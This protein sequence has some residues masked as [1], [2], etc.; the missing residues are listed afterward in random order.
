MEDSIIRLDQDV[1]MK[2]EWTGVTDKLH[3]EYV[4][5]DMKEAAI[6]LNRIIHY[7]GEEFG[8]E[9]YVYHENLAPGGQF[10]QELSNLRSQISHMYRT[11]DDAEL[12]KVMNLPE[13]I[14][15]LQNF[16]YTAATQF[17]EEEK[18]LIQ[19][20]LLWDRESATIIPD[21]AW[22][23]FWKTVDDNKM[24]MLDEVNRYGQNERFFY[25]LFL[26]RVR[27]TLSSNTFTFEPMSPFKWSKVLCAGIGSILGV[28]NVAVALPTAGIALAS[29][30]AGGISTALASGF[31]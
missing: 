25:G 1:R 29:M 17:R 19:D 18:R 28:V 9:N 15:F 24:K 4:R 13:F 26:N 27:P 14:N 16:N 30:V 3:H 21:E 23:R 6:S 8:A 22:N 7:F 11:F 2:P 12:S 31:E 5:D 20:I 10:E